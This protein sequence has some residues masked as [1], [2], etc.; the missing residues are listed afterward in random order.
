MVRYNGV[1]H[2]AMATGDMDMTIRYWPDLLGM[3][4][5]AGMSG[6]DFKKTAPIVEITLDKPHL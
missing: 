1:N 2:L 6:V 3:R 5:V 4:L